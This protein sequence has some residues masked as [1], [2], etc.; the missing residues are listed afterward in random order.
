M[1]PDRE[2]IQALLELREKLRETI[3]KLE[4]TMEELKRVLEGIGDV[5]LEE[6]VVSADQ[7][8]KKGVAKTEEEE[9]RERVITIRSPEGEIGTITVDLA[10]RSIS[11]EPGSGVHIPAEAKPISSFLS[12]RV[13]EDLRKAQ[14]SLNYSLQTGDEGEVKSINISNL[15]E[16]QINDLIGKLIWA[17]RKA[18]G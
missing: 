1:I 13:V 10:T 4:L 16:L 2:R 6:T 14:P 15:N 3:E 5:L 17:V 9:G 11:F 18:V 7:L 8:T 12:E